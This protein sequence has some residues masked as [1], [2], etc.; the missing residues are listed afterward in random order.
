MA[1]VPGR[2]LSARCDDQDQDQ[3]QEQEQEQEQEQDQEQDQ[4]QD[5]EQEQEQDQNQAVF[6]PGSSEAYAL[7]R[8]ADPDEAKQFLELID[9][10]PD[11]IEWKLICLDCD[12][13]L[14]GHHARHLQSQHSISATDEDISRALELV[15][16]VA[17][18]DQTAQDA[19]TCRP[20]FAG[21]S[22]MQGYR[23]PCCT[24]CFISI[25]DWAQHAR[26]LH[27]AEPDAQQQPRCV[28][29]QRI[30]EDDQSSS[31]IEV[32]G[33]KP[34][35]GPFPPLHPTYERLG[36]GRLLQLFDRESMRFFGFGEREE[37]L[38]EAM[39]ELV[40][41]T[42]EKLPLLGMARGVLSQLVAESGKVL[43]LYFPAKLSPCSFEWHLEI[44]TR[45]VLYLLEVWA[46]PTESPNN[47]SPAL[48][49]A[50]GDLAN[51]YRYGEGSTHAAMSQV[52]CAILDDH[53]V[54]PIKTDNYC[55]SIFTLCAAIRSDYTFKHPSTW[56]P[57]LA[58]L[59]W[60][61]RLF[62]LR[63]RGMSP[64]SPGAL[65]QDE[66]VQQ[67]LTEGYICYFLAD[68]LVNTHPDPADQGQP[69]GESVVFE[70]PTPS[71]NEHH[72][73]SVGP[74]HLSLDQLGQGL[75][76][77]RAEMHRIL[78]E[79]LLLDSK[80]EEQVYA[81]LPTLRD[82]ASL[83]PVNFE[84]AGLH[85]ED[86]DGNEFTSTLFRHILFTPHLRSQ[87][88]SPSAPDRLM[89]APIWDWLCAQHNFACL[90]LAYA[91]LSCGRSQACST[92]HRL[93][94]ATGHRLTAARCLGLPP[95]AISYADLFYRDS[96]FRSRNVLYF[97]GL[98]TFTAPRNVTI[99]GDQDAARATY[100]LD[101]EASSII[102]TY[103]LLCK[104]LEAYFVDYVRDE[105]GNGVAPQVA[106]LSE[107]DQDD[108]EAD[109]LAMVEN[110][111]DL[112]ASSFGHIQPTF[113]AH[114]PAPED[115]AEL[116][117]NLALTSGK[118]VTPEQIYDAV[119]T[120]T[121]HFL[122]TSITVSTWR[123]MS[124]AWLHAL[125]LDRLSDWED[126]LG[127][128]SQPSAPQTKPST[129]RLIA[130]AWHRLLG[131]YKADKATST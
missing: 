106:P 109:L 84:W 112:Y 131:L 32:Q 25:D 88:L 56:R 122:G 2:E 57:T 31:F 9:L 99:M 77:M 128:R 108:Y 68:R 130:M 93:P 43:R 103:L 44:A 101:E 55:P 29:M 79:E 70:A 14:A 3:D 45:Y 71:G 41:S 75:R 27:Q 46:Y 6:D 80:L 49:K 28:S 4:D 33:P 58:G 95:R 115:S 123:Q 59:L 54:P 10:L 39:R 76:R 69:G 48:T 20:P 73:L 117:F 21:I 65:T 7:R 114:L 18:P 26:N 42:Y 74:I 53:T 67:R 82:R 121:K 86:A 51:A 16:S 11:P 124:A 60:V 61:C 100:Y 97:D 125:V 127:T 126:A 111:E 63:R 52:W 91:H 116:L 17:P 1:T 102:M 83:G 35:T 92:M 12:G 118:E 110:E 107:E 22:V 89:V 90:A 85:A 98:V 87:F 50:L 96:T 47:L 36:M 13:V 19:A 105:Q 113:A 94:E 64:Y 78:T 30:W 34:P 24:A 38:H 120:N 104:P 119:A 15:R 66:D 81:V 5:Q 8:G 23:C 37:T 72:S 129:D 40:H 62:L